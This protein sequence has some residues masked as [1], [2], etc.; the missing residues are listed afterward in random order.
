MPT[1]VL[2]TLFQTPVRDQE[3]LRDHSSI[4]STLFVLSLLFVFSHCEPLHKDLYLRGPLPLCH[5]TNAVQR[6][7]PQVPSLSQSIILHGRRINMYCR[8]CDIENNFVHSYNENNGDKIWR[9]FWRVVSSDD[10]LYINR[11]FRSTL[12]EDID[13]LWG[14]LTISEL[15]IM[16]WMNDE[17]LWKK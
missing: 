3:H 8:I 2:F 14:R 9:D 15:M 12:C 6:L 10:Y 7:A 11:K 5:T 16:Y 13:I 17:W 4:S 1:L